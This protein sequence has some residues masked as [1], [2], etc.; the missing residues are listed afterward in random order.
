M[1]TFIKKMLSKCKTFLSL[2]GIQ[3]GRGTKCNYLCR[4]TGKTIIGNNCHFN[5]MKI[6]GGCENR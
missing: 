1:K 2:R 4:F 6:A 3:H 5:G